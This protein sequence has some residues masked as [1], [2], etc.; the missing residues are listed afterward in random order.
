MKSEK[1]LKKQMSGRLH[2]RNLHQGRY[3]LD[4]LEVSNV[5]L[6]PFIIKNPKG[7]K[8]IDFSNADAVMALNKALLAKYYG[9]KHWAIP[10][11]YLCP[12]IPGRADYIHYLADL[13]AESTDNIPPKGSNISALDI[14]TGANLI[15]PII[16]SQI[17]GWRFVGS[18]IDPISIKTAKETIKANNK[19]LSRVDICQQINSDDLFKNVISP[20]DSF[21]LIMCNPP[22][23]KSIEDANKG[24]QR[25]L[26][27]LSKSKQKK[28][29]PAKKPALN[30]GGQKA[31]LWCVGGELAFII[32]MISFFSNHH[33]I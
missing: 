2:D 20:S 4:A 31:E 14:G 11:G 7:Q 22:F 8:T 28:V 25:K 12:P 5:E 9:I 21:H 30:F 27:N 23:H 17:Y 1:P 18:D 3:D 15:Y 33:Q 24:S 29:K 6:K 16:G 19:L 10:P 13:L 26:N 32:R